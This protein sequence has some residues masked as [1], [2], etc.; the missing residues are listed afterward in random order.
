MQPNELFVNDGTGDT[1]LDVSAA[2]GADDTGD[3]KGVAFADYDRDGDIDLFVVDQGGAP[4]L[5]RNDTPR[6]SNHWLEVDTV[7]TSSDRD[8]CGARVDGRRTWTHD[9]A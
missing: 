1:F 7:G 4:Q 5:L 3:S 9:A 8:G 2:T 6:G